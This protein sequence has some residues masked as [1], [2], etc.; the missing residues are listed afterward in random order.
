[1]NKMSGKDKSLLQSLKH[2]DIDTVFV[3]ISIVL[4]RY[5]IIVLGRYIN[6]FR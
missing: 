6:R 2:V 1:L 3:D 4:G 5:I